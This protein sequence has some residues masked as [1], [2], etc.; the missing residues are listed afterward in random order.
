MSRQYRQLVLCPRGDEQSISETVL[1]TA[2]AE[3]GMLG[4]RISQTWSHRYFIGDRFLQYVSFMGCAPALEFRPTDP[5]A[6]DWSG[7]T[8]I[9]VTPAFASER[10]LVDTQMARPRCPHCGKRHVMNNVTPCDSL[11]C[12][13]CGQVSRLN[14]WD[15]RE[16]GACARQFI[17]IANVYPKESIPTETLLQHLYEKTQ[18]HWRYFYIN[19]ELLDVQN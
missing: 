7:F 2:L 14:A 11:T 17:S 4:E 5:G 16:F 1:T 9:S 6:P 8:F 3:L 15:F 10:C 19:D 13:V 18:I 12:P